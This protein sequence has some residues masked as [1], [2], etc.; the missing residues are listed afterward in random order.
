MEKR[1]N[2]EGKIEKTRKNRENKRKKRNEGWDEGE[3]DS[4]DRAIL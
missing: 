4:K 1:E 2:L 3:Q